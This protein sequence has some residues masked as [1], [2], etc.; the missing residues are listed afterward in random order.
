MS[1]D[2]ILFLGEGD[3]NVKRVRNLPIIVALVTSGKM[4]CKSSKAVLLGFFSLNGF[5]SSSLVGLLVFFG[6]S[7]FSSSSIV[8]AVDLLS[9]LA[10]GTFSRS[11]VTAILVEQMGTLISW[12]MQRSSINYIG[13]FLVKVYD[14]VSLTAR[15]E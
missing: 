8:L 13:L 9:D 11:C 6:S 2:F 1:V 5:F 7:K 10:R 12:T 14:M 4:R 3:C 15:E